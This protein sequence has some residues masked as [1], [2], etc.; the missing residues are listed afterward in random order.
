MSVTNQPDFWDKLLVQTLEE[1]RLYYPNVDL[2]DY[3]WWCEEIDNVADEYEEGSLTPL[4]A[5]IEIFN[6]TVS[7]YAMALEESFEVNSETDPEPP[8][9]G[10]STL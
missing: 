4:E 10:S 1:E 6:I 9:T 5:R 3:P 2:A 7:Q 8:Y